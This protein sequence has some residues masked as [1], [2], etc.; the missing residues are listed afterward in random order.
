MIGDRRIKRLFVRVTWD[1]ALKV[2]TL[3]GSLSVS[4]HVR[5]LL[6]LPVR[7]RAADPSPA[8]PLPRPSKTTPAAPG[9]ADLSRQGSPEGTAGTED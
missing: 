9:L 8:S 7:R 5:K 6:G 2:K 3:A 1:E 4:D